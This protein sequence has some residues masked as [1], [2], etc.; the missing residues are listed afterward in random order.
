[1]N[2]EHTQAAWQSRTNLMAFA[3]IVAFWLQRQ[4]GVQLPVEIQGFAVDLV[5]VAITGFMALSIW[6]RNKAR[7]IVDRWF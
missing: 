3:G 1:M 2:P 5:P 4:T 7:A 6:F